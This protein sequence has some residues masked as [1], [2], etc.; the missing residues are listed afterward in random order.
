MTYIQL[1]H[2]W[3]KNEIE[4]WDSSRFNKPKLRY[5]NL[6]KCTVEPEDYVINK[7]LS[8]YH[9]SLLAQFRCG[10][11]PIEV[12]LGRFRNI[13]LENRICPMCHSDVEDEFHLLSLCNVYDDLR[14]VLYTKTSNL[15]PDFD[16]FDD[17]EKFMFINDN[18]QTALS[19]FLYSAMKRR[20]ECLYNSQDS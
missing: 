5:Y 18:M 17:V 8:K 12:E 9:R 20:K 13:D 1:D 15:Y 2:V 14:T 3:K 4:L 6:Y 16:S 19:K 11:L 10:I 7:N